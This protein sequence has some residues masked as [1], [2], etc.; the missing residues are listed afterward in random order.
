MSPIERRIA[1]IKT[2]IKLT[3]IA[4]GY[5]CSV[6]AVTRTLNDNM[7]SRPLLQYINRLVGIPAKRI[8]PENARRKGLVAA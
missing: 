4:N 8:F 3:D 5:G 2:R 7:T 1:L 6:A